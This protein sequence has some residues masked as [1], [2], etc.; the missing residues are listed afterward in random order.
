MSSEPLHTAI[1]LRK[2]RK[3]VEAER[4]AAK[5]GDEYDTLSKHRFELLAYAKREEIYVQDI[6]EE[7]V[8]GEF[9]QERPAMQALLQKVKALA[10]DAVLVADLDR[11]GRGDKRDQGWIEKIFKDSNTL[12]ITPFEKHDL[13]QELGEFTVEVKSFLARMEYKQIKK[14]LQSG[15]RRSVLEGKELSQKPPYGYAKD[16]NLFLLVEPAEADIVT[17]IYDWYIAGLGHTRIA[18]KLTTAGIPSPSGQPVWSRVT[19]SKILANPKY[20]G[21]QVFG[22]TRWIKQEDGSYQTRK[23]RANEEIYRKIAA[24]EPI[25]TPERWDFAQQ[26]SVARRPSLSPQRRHLINPF[27]GVLICRLCGKSLQANFPKNRPGP[28]LSCHTPHCPQRMIALHKVEEVVYSTIRPIL[29][30]LAMQEKINN[31]SKQ[32]ATSAMSLQNTLKKEWERLQKRRD[33]LCEL[34]E[35]G[36]YSSSLYELRNSQLT[37]DIKRIEDKLASSLESNSATQVNGHVR[38]DF[39]NA[40]DV[41]AYATIEQKNRIVKAM[42]KQISYLRKPEWKAPRQFSLAITLQSGM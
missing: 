22:R 10:Y 6:F 36:I 24:H 29:E 41:Y 20:K 13:N 4:E 2:S 35:R 31:T 28:Y 40:W 34:L 30:I 12:I 7:V 1:Y 26:L 42:I 3:D 32:Q 39:N 37:A 14:R 33:K 27:A 23:A 15:R 17:Q 11:L 8:S 38:P 25:I 21:D 18:E 9:I 19:I 5:R 16:A